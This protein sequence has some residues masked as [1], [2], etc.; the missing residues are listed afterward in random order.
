MQEENLSSD[1]LLFKVLY[2]LCQF[3]AVFFFSFFIVVLGYTVAFTKV[4][5]IYQT[6]HTSIHP[7]KHSLLSPP[8]HFWSSFNSSHFHLHICEH[9]ICT[10]FT[11]PHPFPISSPLPLVLN[12]PGRTYPAFLFSNLIKEKTMTFLCV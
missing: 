9:S 12:P 11:L 4:L 2:C 1:V 5:A 6:Y 3:E 7:L 10:I 8:P